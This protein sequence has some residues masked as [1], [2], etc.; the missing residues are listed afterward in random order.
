MPTQLSAY[1]SKDKNKVQ[2]GITNLGGYDKVLSATNNIYSNPR[3][4]AAGG[5]AE[6]GGMATVGDIDGLTV[7]VKDGTN[8]IDDNNLKQIICTINAGYAFPMKNDAGNIIA[9]SQQGSQN[10]MLC[11]QE[12]G[13]PFALNNPMIDP[14]KSKLGSDDVCAGIGLDLAFWGTNYLNE[15]FAYHTCNGTDLQVLAQKGLLCAEVVVHSSDSVGSS[16]KVFYANVVDVMAGLQYVSL[17]S[18]AFAALPKYQEIGVNM[19]AS[20]PNGDSFRIGDGKYESAGDYSYDYKTGKLG[21]L[22]ADTLLGMVSTAQCAGTINILPQTG[23]VCRIR[24]FV[25]EDRT[26]EAEEAINKKLPTE[27]SQVNKKMEYTG[28]QHVEIQSNALTGNLQQ[29]IIN[30]GR[31]IMEFISANGLSYAQLGG[32]PKPREQAPLGL[33]SKLQ[34]VG[35]KYCPTGTVTA[36]PDNGTYVACDCSLYV[37]W[38]LNEVGVMKG[39][40]NSVLFGQASSSAMVSG[41]KLEQIPSPEAGCVLW[42]DGHVALC[43]STS[44][45]YSFGSTAWL[46]ELASQAGRAGW[47]GQNDNTTHKSKISLNQPQSLKGYTKFFR[48][49]K[50]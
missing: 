20:A 34:E 29:D 2:I 24:L 35:L 36:V 42:R 19:M 38:V 49:V 5:V 43:I 28:C 6:V 31:I 18:P 39:R 10:G 44:Q 17:L 13:I 1:L 16:G 45:C 48:I 50:S 8:F 46:P 33:S 21:G 9:A 12:K 30:T 32:E 26:S 14:I 47:K 25:P 4:S 7:K 3:I 27:F 22:N 37:S 11:Y 41:Y 40:Y 15:F 23:Q